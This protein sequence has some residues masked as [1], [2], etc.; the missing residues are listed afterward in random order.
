MVPRPSVAGWLAR[1]Y[2]SRALARAVVV[3]LV[4]LLVTQSLMVWYF[5]SVGLSLRQLS[6][7]DDDRTV[8]I[9]ESDVRTFE[10]TYHPEREEGWC[11]YGAVNDT[12]VRVDDVVHADPVVQE[13]DHVQFTCVG[14]TTGQALRGRNA[15]LIG[16]AHSHPSKDRSY[17]SR[18]DTMTWARTSPVVEV[19]G[20]YTE[21]DGIEFFTVR[22]LHRPLPQD[23][24]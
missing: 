22:S 18:A 23:V 19:M 10:E 3:L 21:G 4:A 9:D 1:R 14:E 15:N 13:K 2:S 17:L 8:V 24:R 7:A 5:A 20:V 12:H 6:P 16:V 11:L